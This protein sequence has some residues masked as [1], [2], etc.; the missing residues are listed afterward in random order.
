MG[1]AKETPVHRLTLAI[2][3]SPPTA[4]RSAKA[5]STRP[6]PRIGGRK[7]ARRSEFVHV[8]IGRHLPKESVLSGRGFRQ[9]DSCQ[10]T[11]ERPG[12]RAECNETDYG[13]REKFGHYLAE[14]C[15]FEVHA[16]RN[17]DRVAEGIDESEIL[18]SNRHVRYRRGETRQQCKR[19]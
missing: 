8:L 12:R 1:T 14:A 10:P 3:Q 4:C 7:R 2:A 16:M 11:A 9:S 13:Q 15:A 5:C 17:V 18:Q 19:H 6:A